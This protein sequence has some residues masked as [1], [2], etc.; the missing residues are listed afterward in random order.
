MKP[1]VSRIEQI[2]WGVK[3]S[4]CAILLGAR[5]R[6]RF[7]YAIELRPSPGLIRHYW[8]SSDPADLSH[9]TVAVLHHPGGRGS[10]L[11]HQRFKART[12]SKRRRPGPASRSRTRHSILIAGGIGVTPIMSH[13]RYQCSPRIR[14]RYETMAARRLRAATTNDVGHL[15]P[16]CT[17]KPG[18]RTPFAPRPIGSRKQRISLRREREGYRIERVNLRRW[19]C[20]AGSV[21]APETIH[22]CGVQPRRP[23]AASSS[24]SVNSDSEA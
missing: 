23:T 10:S 5:A 15:A 9:H 12:R 2:A 19:V 6:L 16:G 8:L 1:T 7:P 14:T 17:S 20:I 18:S 4:N 3:L 21:L 11:L 22:S 24:M 13:A